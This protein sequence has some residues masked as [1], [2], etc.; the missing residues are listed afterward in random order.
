MA[1]NRSRADEDN[2]VRQTYVRQENRRSWLLPLG[3]GSLIASFGAG[4]LCMLLPATESKDASFLATLLDRIIS[5]ESD[6]R[7]DLSI[8]DA[9]ITA[10]LVFIAFLAIGIVILAYLRNDRE[11]FYTAFP[12]LALKFD[13]SEIRSARRQ[14]NICIIA[15]CAILAG[16]VTAFV[17]F[18]IFRQRYLGE[19]IGFLLS[20]LGAAV[21]LHGWTASE[22]TDIFEYNYSA[23]K[24]AN[25][26]YLIANQK[27]PDRNAIINVKRRILK[28]QATMLIILTATA[29]ASF[30]LLLLPSLHTS[31][32]WIPVSVGLIACLIVDKASMERSRAEL[33][34]EMQ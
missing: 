27:G 7:L 18:G 4:S 15:G 10:I 23:L 25:V 13:E 28:A 29:L 5:Q 11:E 32:F 8:N 1:D 19:G 24:H 14:R 6:D 31:L 12:N 9:H 34:A 26:Y 20:A 3:V 21:F 2:I 33:D 22:R 30:A 16:A 17:L